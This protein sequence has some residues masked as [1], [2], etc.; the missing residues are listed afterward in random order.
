MRSSA[1]ALAIFLLGCGG[2][3]PPSS[4]SS[5]PP[6]AATLYPTPL[7]Q[8]QGPRAVPVKSVCLDTHLVSQHEAVD[9]VAPEL[10]ARAGLTR[11]ESGAACD[12]PLTL[13][14]VAPVDLDVDGAAAWRDAGERQ[15]AA[16]R[17]A[18]VNALVGPTV[19]GALYG[20][21][22]RARLDALAA[23]LGLVDGQQRVHGAVVV[24]APSIARR[25]LVEGYYGTP[26]SA[27]Q[28]RCLLRAMVRL[29]Q[30]TYL[31]GPKNDPFAHERWA[32]PYP[33]ADGAAIAAAAAQA[34]ARLIDFI[35]SVSPGL[36]AGGT[37]PGGSISFASADDFA[38]LT[39]K[40]DAMR[41]LGVTHF[42]LFL[43]DTDP[44]LVWPA[45]Q[46]MFAD[47]AEAHADLA[48]RLDQ[49]VT[50]FDSSAHILFVGH[51]YSNLWSAWQ[52]YSTT[53][54]QKLRPGIDVLWTGPG[55]YSLSMQASDMIGVD[56]ALG[57]KVV[58]W[59]NQPTGVVPLE[60]RSAD[61][62]DG[63]SGFLS[64]PVLIEEHYQ[65]DDFWSVLG[66]LAD[67]T[68]NTTAYESQRSF[69]NWDM[70]KGSCD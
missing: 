59:D 29:R 70:L 44:D 4:P 33:T 53:L 13:Y 23:A 38:R 30:N 5:Q 11:A 55:V 6:P 8:V 61:L 28:R 31:Y 7:Y 48:N 39:A 34:K 47:I 67:Y 56:Q 1:L 12:W 36:I 15:G 54:G 25:G 26:F 57:R 16:E 62:P 18:I 9:A 50:G 49:Y 41:G 22:E 19:S 42:A 45:D 37:P 60:M 10:I 24:D 69:A 3:R 46:Q 66:T 43:D 68:W 51:Y 17:Y 35:W 27:D 2:A 65:F 14:D 40:I 58:I 20:E 32:D 63:I 64:N 52:D 21:S